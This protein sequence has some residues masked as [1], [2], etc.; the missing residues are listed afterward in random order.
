M[1]HHT[2]QVQ[3]AKEQ[4][5]VENWGAG[6][7]SINTAGQVVCQPLGNSEH[8]VILDDVINSAEQSKLKTPLIIRFPQVIKTQ[9]KRMHSSFDQ[10]IQSFHYTGR[11]YGVF[12][13]KVNQR[14]EFIEAIVS[15]GQDMKWGLEVGSKPEFLAALSYPIPEDSLLTC[16]GFKDEEFI[17]I[18]FLASALGR[19]VIL[20]VEGFDELEMMINKLQKAPKGSKTPSIG[21]RVRLSSKGSGRWEKSSGETSKFGLT[22][23]ELFQ[24]LAHLKSIGQEKSLEMLHFHIGS[25]VTAIKRFK[26]AL[27]EAAR[28]YSKAVHMGFQPAHLNIGGGVGVDYDGSR[29]SAES[30]V[31]YT[32]QEFANDAVYVIGEV[33]REE[34]VACP[35]IVTESGRVIAAYHSVVVTD[36]REVQGRETLQAHEL[37]TL[38]TLEDDHPKALTNLQEIAQ[39]MHAE[40]YY[41]F[42]HDA[43]E[44]HEELGTLF[45]MGYLTLH[46]RA[47]GDHLYQDI[48]NK[49]LEFAA[50]EP[51]LNDEFQI[52]QKNK[53]TKY[54]ANFSMFQSI[55]D[56]W[57]IDQLFPVMPLARH[58]EKPQQKATIMDITCDSDG[59]LDRFVDTQKIKHSLELH[60]PNGNPYHIGFFLVGAYQESL[61]NEHN[62]FGAIHEVEVHIKADG[63]WEISKL[64]PGD[65]ADELLTCRNYDMKEIIDSYGKQADIHIKDPDERKT[66][67]TSLTH[68]LGSYPYLNKPSNPHL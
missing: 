65:C 24:A 33:C 11:H 28:V 25:Q 29:S 27:K 4:Y 23:I 9:L 20:I 22:P 14:R 39:S 59:C 47:I 13:F 51:R 34:K 38:N 52:L 60:T 42:Y 26:N 57:A 8:Q 12:P 21:L 44:D 67:V 19:K 31:N 66:L 54:L 62:L 1:T 49:V 30:S 36:I 10:A 35:H 32:L 15:C 45:Q 58:D 53:V 18:A 17:E 46:Q 68:Y 6:Y 61:A 16:N 48:C 63:T 55:P 43:T 41:E 56:S 7:F 5:G 40:N 37:K 50:T 3:K 2:D 64:T